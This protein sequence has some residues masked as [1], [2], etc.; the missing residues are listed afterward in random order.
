M[1]MWTCYCDT[2][3]TQSKANEQMLV[4]VG[5]AATA[6]R[7][8]KFDVRWRKALAEYGVSALHMK[9]FAGGWGEY[10]VWKD[11]KPRRAAFLARFLNEAKR[12][13]NKAF[14]A[15]LIVPDFRAINEEYCIVERVQSPYAFVQSLSLAHMI[16]W[17]ND[18]KKKSDQ[19]LCFLEQG[20]AGQDAFMAEA[21]RVLGWRPATL[22]RN[23]PTGEAYT[24][25]ELC[26]FI[27]YEHRLAYT[28]HMDVDNKFHPRGSFTEMRRHLPF[29]AGIF[30]REMLVKWCAHRAIP[31]R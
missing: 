5:I 23:D 22:P 11:D 6:K 18:T 26:D 3:G 15:G 17:L 21:E 16:E 27:A 25:F 30:D 13:I 4:T 8:T 10:A 24:P 9:D 28:R 14:V 31:K 29:E 12:G 1:V 2:A 20:D 19:V 7:W